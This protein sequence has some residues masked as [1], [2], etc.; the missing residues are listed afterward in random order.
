MMARERHGD[1]SLAIDDGTGTATFLTIARLRADHLTL[2][3][4]RM[5]IDHLNVR[6]LSPASIAGR[7]A[8]AGLEGVGLLEDEQGDVRLQRLFLDGTILCWRILLP[9][10]GTLEGPFR[11]RRLHCRSAHGSDFALV[12]ESHGPIAF[13][14]SAELTGD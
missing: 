10:C 3:G 2:A 12:L 4:D 5:R 11:I 14:A 8:Q 6:A 9:S 7:V 13:E 1:I